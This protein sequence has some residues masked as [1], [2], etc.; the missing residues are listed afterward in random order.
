MTPIPVSDEPDIDPRSKAVQLPAQQIEVH[1]QNANQAINEK[2]VEEMLRRFRQDAPKSLE[3]FPSM[4]TEG[5]YAIYFD[6]GRNF[7][8]RGS[9]VDAGCFVGGTTMSLVQGLL[10]NPLLASNQDKLQGLI[11]VYDLFQIDDDYILGHLQKNYPQRDF[12]GQSSFLG[13]FEDNLSEHAHL[14]DVRPGDVML[15]G[16]N[17]DEPIEILG[18]DLCKALPVTDYVVRT[19]FPRLMDNALVIQ[20]DFIHQ[21]HPHI[22]LSMLLLDDCFEL[23]HELRWGGSLS[24]RLKRPIT[25]EIITQRFGESPEDWFN[26]TERNATLLRGLVDG[27]FFDENRWVMLQ[28]LGIYLANMGEHT[29]AHAAYLEAR[30]RFPFYEIPAEV[31]RL[32][33][34]EAVTA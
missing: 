30:D 12:N 1:T 2:R 32:I 34:A 13:V 24:Y 11:R 10:Q 27:M 3:S 19:F 22:H 26:Q 33:G 28:V 16:Y 7:E 6:A 21:Y 31:E 4:L 14:L 5:D 8:F 23:D 15:A 17:D 20:Q 18:V 29:R 25:P 9:I